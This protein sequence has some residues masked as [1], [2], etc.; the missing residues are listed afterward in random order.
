MTLDLIRRAEAAAT[1]CAAE[2]AALDRHGAFPD[3]ALGRLRTGGYLAAP[4]PADL[5]GAGLC[6]PERVAALCSL[7]TA[8]GRGSLAVGRLYEGHVNALALALRYGS[9][10]A[11]ASLARD[12]RAGHLFGVWN[13]EPEPGGLVLAED[14]LR[15]A[16][17]F[18][19][20]AGHVTRPLVTARLADG[21]RQMLVV[22]LAPGERADLS[23]WRAQG[24]RAT[25][26][27]RVDL[28]GLRAADAAQV[29][30]PDDYA[31]QPFF[32]GGAWRFM[33]VQLG[34][35]EAVVEAHRAH[36]RATGRGADPHQQA[37]L[38][39]ALIA[40]E[41]CR[42]LVA[43][44]AEAVAAERAGAER[45]VAYVNLAR[46]AVE[47]AGLDVIALAQR[48]VGLAGFL[49]DHPLE[50]LTRDLATY[51]RQPAPDYALTSA[52]AYALAEEAPLPALWDGLESEQR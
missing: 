42:L 11:R 45:I 40:A 33:A 46:A 18:A 47:Q 34:G 38:G 35:I 2:A 27:G 4:L 1:P 12:A 26:T 8:I 29:G 5:G 52:A 50:R 37:R 21:R 28:T 23:A 36:M 44:A 14:A 16:K 39:R 15:G 24:M 32:F 48:S 51:L 3:A 31:R 41:S 30:A 9:D 10:D 25:A 13:T 6:E 43:R 22:P 19:S 20:G 17:S 7:L 49:E